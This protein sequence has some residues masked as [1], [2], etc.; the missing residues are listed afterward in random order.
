M[1]TNPPFLKFI[2]LQNLSKCFSAFLLF[3]FLLFCFLLFAVFF[4]SCRKEPEKYILNFAGEGICIESQTVEDGKYATKPENPERNC[5]IFRGWF[6]DDG[7]FA[8]EW[9]FNAGVVTQDTTLYAKWEEII[10]QGTEWKLK[11][12]M[13]V[14]TGEL[15]V[16]E[17][18]DCGR[19][20]TLIF[21]TDTSFVTY[22]SVNE[23]FGKYVHD[24]SNHSFQIIRIMGTSVDG[25][26]DEKFYLHPF[27]HR[28][29]HAFSLN[30][31]ELRLYYYYLAQV[32]DIGQEK[33]LLFNKK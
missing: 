29:I 5:C 18:Q 9:D 30:E 25:S 4:S 1:K 19:C 13:D 33:Y 27:F 7:T 8:N 21:D 28:L 24:C 26:P 16:L 3:C 20:Y 22:T 23:N 10:L 17:P 6:T 15:K 11:G 32:N 14:R 31:N 12:I 2:R